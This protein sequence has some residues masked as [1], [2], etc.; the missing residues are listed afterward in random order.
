[1]R[2]DT[3]AGYEGLDR[4]LPSV[5]SIVCS[6]L[7]TAQTTG[8]RNS[9]LRRRRDTTGD[10]VILVIHWKGGSH[11]EI[12]VPRR[13]R[14]YNNAHTDKGLIESVGLLANICD[15]EFIAGVLNHN[16]HETGRGNR[17]TK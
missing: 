17:W 12:R 16:G 6:C 10:E 2:S 4:K 15:D 11:T 8:D 7:R 9:F 14:G 3:A 13:R 5:F 1:M